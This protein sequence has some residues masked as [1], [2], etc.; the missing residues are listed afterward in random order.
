MDGRYVAGNSVARLDNGALM[1]SG[2]SNA[3][4]TTQGW[5]AGRRAAGSPNDLPAKEVARLG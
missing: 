2:M 4:S 1:Q 3:R 5:L